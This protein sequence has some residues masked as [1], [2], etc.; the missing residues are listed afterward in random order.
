MKKLLLL[1]AVFCS[2]SFCL[3]AQTQTENNGGTENTEEDINPKTG[4][5]LIKD[6]PYIIF[7]EG[8]TFATVVRLEEMSGR[9]NF[10]WQDYMIG[11][12]F[13]VQSVNMKPCN[14]MIKISA[15][16]PFSHEFN[17]VEQ[18][19]KQTILYAFDLFAGPIFETNMWEYVRLKYG[20]GLHYMY[21][22]SDEYHLH[23]LGLGLLTGTELPVAH[24]WTILVNA[25]FDLDYPNLGTNKNIQP[26]DYS[27]QYHVDVGIRYSRKKT[28]KY[29]YVRQVKKLF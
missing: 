10:V 9:S 8:V 20:I 23:Y 26:F 16:Y 21:Q 25:G 27:W 18:I 7:D 11:A 12:Y 29:S 14:S 17:D 19:A 6:R 3:Y 4:F 2:L 24:R 22:L 13:A 28:N 15:Y 5:P 1:A